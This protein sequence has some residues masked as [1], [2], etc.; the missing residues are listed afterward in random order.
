MRGVGIGTESLQPAGARVLLQ[1]SL[2]VPELPLLLSYTDMAPSSSSESKVGLA[3]HCRRSPLSAVGGY[4]RCASHHSPAALDAMSVACC[5]SVLRRPRGLI[6]RV[7]RLPAAALPPVSPASH[8]SAPHTPLPPRTVCSP[9]LRLSLSLARHASSFSGADTESE[10]RPIPLRHRRRR[11]T[12][13]ELYERELEAMLRERG[14]RQQRRRE[15]EAQTTEEVAADGGLPEVADFFDVDYGDWDADEDVVRLRQAALSDEARADNGGSSLHNLAIHR[16]IR[17]KE[18]VRDIVPA[19]LRCQSALPSSAVDLGSLP[20]LVTRVRVSSDLQWLTVQ[21]TLMPHRADSSLCR[22]PASLSGRSLHSV[23]TLVASQLTACIGPIRRQ[24][25]SRLTTRYV[26]NVRFVYD[27]DEWRRRRLDRQRA[28][29]VEHRLS[30]AGLSSAEPVDEELS[31]HRFNPFVAS[32]S[33]GSGQAVLARP[34]FSSGAAS[35]VSV[36][37]ARREKGRS[38]HERQHKR[39]LDDIKRTGVVNGQQR[40]ARPIQQQSTSSR[41]RKRVDEWEWIKKQ[42][43]ALWESEG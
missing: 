13:E 30:S 42:Q 10:Q 12:E 16:L 36:Q 19:V 22:L 24:L 2:L 33:G 38:R 27:S 18:A 5:C 25:A 39:V 1:T 6:A 28:R 31:F 17:V 32:T 43:R 41:P 8:F 37:R 26:P 7:A 23:L 35:I 15:E 20:L 11:A 34:R 4:C 14:Q 3:A 40:Y 9:N 21:W 29:D